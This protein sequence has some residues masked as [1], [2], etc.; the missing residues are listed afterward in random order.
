MYNLQR[1]IHSRDIAFGTAIKT[2]IESL[3][4][5]QKGKRDVSLLPNVQTRSGVHTAP[6][7]VVT[8]D[9]S[10]VVKAAET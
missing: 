4:E 6:Y 2:T 9:Y 5:L 3:F 1:T 7:S 8:G 10:A